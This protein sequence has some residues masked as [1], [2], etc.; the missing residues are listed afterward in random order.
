MFTLGIMLSTKTLK[1][2]IVRKSRDPLI[3]DKTNGRGKVRW[4]NHRLRIP[5]S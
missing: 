2:E 4:E 1:R 5:N 3:V